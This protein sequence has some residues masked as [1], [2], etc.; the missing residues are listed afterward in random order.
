MTDNP[1]SIHALFSSRREAP[2][3]VAA[4]G[5]AG[6]MVA[7]A[8]ANF[9]ARF[10]TMK[11]NTQIYGLWCLMSLSAIFQ[12]Y[13]DGLFLLDEEIGVPKENHRPV[14]SH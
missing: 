7:T 12:L 4:A 2:G 5:A 10:V 1:V 14:E 9:A 8:T 6:D 13:R 11:E 3:A